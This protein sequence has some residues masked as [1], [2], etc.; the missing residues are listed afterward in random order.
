MKAI[1]ANAFSDI[2]SVVRMA[3]YLNLLMTCRAPSGL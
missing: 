2:I 3:N 1:T